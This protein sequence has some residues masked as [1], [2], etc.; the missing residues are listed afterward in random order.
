[1]NFETVLN[2]ATV[3]VNHTYG[4]PE[5]GILTMTELSLTTYSKGKDVDCPI[6]DCDTTYSCMWLPKFVT[7]YRNIRSHKTGDNNRQPSV[8]AHPQL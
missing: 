4:K 5:G 7:I 8:F 3:S 6:L 1:M 2:H